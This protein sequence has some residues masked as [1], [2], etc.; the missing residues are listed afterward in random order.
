M[1]GCNKL[2]YLQA[3]KNSSASGWKSERSNRK[4]PVSSLR[5]NKLEM[6]AISINCWVPCE[7]LPKKL[8]MVFDMIEL[9][10]Q[11]CPFIRELRSF[12]LKLKQNWFTTVEFTC[13]TST[14]KWGFDSW[15]D[16]NKFHFCSNSDTGTKM[17]WTN[18][19]NGFIQA[20]NFVWECLERFIRHCN[21]EYLNTLLV[22]KLLPHD[23]IFG[24]CLINSIILRFYCTWMLTWNVST[25]MQITVAVQFDPISNF[26]IFCSEVLFYL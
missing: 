5:P 9:V 22:R 24:L 23:S 17:R 26:W 4:I 13:I 7:L 12:N 14:C 2:Q 15:N 3:M 6:D 11:A 18:M 8:N 21:Y 25:L 19:I 1:C 20:Q 16:P 10:T